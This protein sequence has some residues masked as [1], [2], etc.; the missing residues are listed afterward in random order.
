MWDKASSSIEITGKSFG[1]LQYLPKQ[2]RKEIV[3]LC[4]KYDILQIP[5]ENYLRNP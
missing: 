1:L 4:V 5:K 3:K 2:Q